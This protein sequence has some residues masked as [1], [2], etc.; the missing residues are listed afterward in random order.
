MTVFRAAMELKRV[1]LDRS[2]DKSSTAARILAM[3]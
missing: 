2:Q 1:T 3:E